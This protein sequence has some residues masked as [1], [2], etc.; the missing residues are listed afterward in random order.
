MIALFAILGLRSVI[1]FCS[2]ECAAYGV[3]GPGSGLDLANF[4][5]RC[6]S[7]KV[8]SAALGKGRIGPDGKEKPFLVEEGSK[9]TLEKITALMSRDQDWAVI[10]PVAMVARCLFLSGFG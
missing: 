6:C 8:S 7:C 9:A 10:A 5:A 2:V 3:P 1:C 4:E